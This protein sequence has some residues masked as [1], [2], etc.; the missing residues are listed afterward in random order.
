MIAEGDNP[1][2]PV[3]SLNGGYCQFRM[4]SNFLRLRKNFHSGPPLV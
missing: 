2:D 1:I 3:S 4:A